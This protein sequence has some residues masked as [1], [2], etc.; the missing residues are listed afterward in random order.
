MVKTWRP[1]S[2]RAKVF[3]GKNVLIT[4]EIQISS[5]IENEFLNNSTFLDL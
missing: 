3:T 2:E 1:G 5:T 4:R